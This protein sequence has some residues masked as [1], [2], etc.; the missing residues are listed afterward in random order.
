[1]GGKSG[2]GLGPQLEGPLKSVVGQ[3]FMLSNLVSNQC[4]YRT[5][6]PSP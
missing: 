6:F 3:V 4:E 5:V 1:M 2:H